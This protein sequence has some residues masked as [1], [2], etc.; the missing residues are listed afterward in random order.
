MFQGLASAGCWGCFDEFNRI[1]LDVLSVIT[2]YIGS[3]F[4]ALRQGKPEAPC[5]M[6]ARTFNVK[7]DCALFITMNPGYAGRQELPDNLAALFRPVAMMVPDFQAIAK[8]ELMAQGFVH[9]EKLAG[10]ITTIVDLMSKQLSKQSHYNYGMRE[11]KSM[12]RHSGTI[13]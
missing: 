6:E 11:I 8:I 3:I 2:T 9:S 5:T 4:E 7:K 10:K 12:L 13:K 1:L